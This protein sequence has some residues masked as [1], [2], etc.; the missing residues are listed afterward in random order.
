M[1]EKQG[2]SHASQRFEDEIARVASLSAYVFTTR[3]LFYE[4][5]RR[6]Q[7]VLPPLDMPAGGSSI[8]AAATI[9]ALFSA[10]QAASGDYETVFAYDEICDYALLSNAA[11]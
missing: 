10:A 1:V 8:A 4:A 2:W 9:G 5:L 6:A 3:L 7:P 11:V